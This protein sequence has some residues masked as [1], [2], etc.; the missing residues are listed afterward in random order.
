[1]ADPVKN[2]TIAS[3]FRGINNRVDPTRLGLEWQIEAHNVLCDAAG[4]LVRRPGFREALVADLID[5]YAT[6]SGR[7]LAIDAANRLIEMDREHHVHVLHEGVHGAPFQWAELGYALFL[8]SRAAQWAIYPDR[9]I[10]WG[11]LATTP[12]PDTGTVPHD[13]QDGGLLSL[14]AP[15]AEA[16]YSPPPLGDV[17]GACRNHLV[18]AVWE[19]HLDRSV[20]Y[21]SRPDYPHHF[22]LSQAQIV[23]GQATYLGMAGALFLIATDRSIYAETPGSPVQK[24]ASFGMSLG[25][26]LR[27]QNGD[28]ILWTQQGWYRA[29]P[30]EPLTQSLVS[31]IQ[32]QQVTA[33]LLLWQGSAYSVVSQTGDASSRCPYQPHQPLPISATHAN[34]IN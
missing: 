2:P 13:P 24:L 11:S 12:I 33:S 25:G 14:V 1:M 20:L 31:P 6:T 27:D 4:Y 18:V 30:F 28:I 3:Q 8:Q 32:R 5:I 17:I 22:N 19:P 23:P 7:L 9:V 34:G 15:V 26:A 10:P 29:N 16:A 21:Y